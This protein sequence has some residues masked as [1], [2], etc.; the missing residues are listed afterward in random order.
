MKHTMKQ[1]VGEAVCK[2]Q[3]LKRS[4]ISNILQKTK[5]RKFAFLILGEFVLSPKKCKTVWLTSMIR[6]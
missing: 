1:I 5:A 4:F 3:K 2:K 6:Y